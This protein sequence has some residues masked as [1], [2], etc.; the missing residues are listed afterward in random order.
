MR[1]TCQVKSKSGKKTSHHVQNVIDLL[2]ATDE[3]YVKWR[4]G[5]RPLLFVGSR[6][7]LTL[8]SA[9]AAVMRGD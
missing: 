8:R 2:L 9:K 6:Y 7:H 1:S 4:K 5:K 3:V